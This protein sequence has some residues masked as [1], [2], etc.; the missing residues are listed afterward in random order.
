MKISR[1]VIFLETHKEPGTEEIIFEEQTVTEGTVNKTGDDN[2]ETIEEK[3]PK[4]ESEDE[5]KENKLTR[6]D[7]QGSEPRRSK[8]LN[9][10]IPPDRYMGALN[11]TVS[12]EEPKDRKEALSRPDAELWIKAM[13]EEMDSLKNN[14]TWDLMIP[15]KERKVIGCKWVYKIKRNTEGKIVKYKARLVAKGFSQKFGKDYDEVFAPVVRHTTFRILLAIAG[16]K[17]LM[18]KHYDAK[19]AFLNGYLKETV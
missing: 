12:L 17:H 2:K 14:K 15:P 11:M 3:G 8:R 13:D 1:N 9:K 5:D 18:I 19:T 6:R 16:K 10:G 4:D 7:V